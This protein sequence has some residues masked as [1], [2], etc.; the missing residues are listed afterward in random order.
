MDVDDHSTSVAVDSVTGDGGVVWD[1]I[2]FFSGGIIEM[3]FRESK[4]EGVI[5][6]AVF[7][8]DWDFSNA[9]HFG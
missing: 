8:E 1:V 4:E 2:F 6:F 9:T 3:G 5:I 7:G